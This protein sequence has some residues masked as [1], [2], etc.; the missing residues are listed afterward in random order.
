MNWVLATPGS[1][2][3]DVAFVFFELSSLLILID[4]FCPFSDIVLQR[5]H[6]KLEIVC[7]IYGSR[8]FKS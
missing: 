7:P 4:S 6:T 3:T 1:L 8:Y 5:V 2:N